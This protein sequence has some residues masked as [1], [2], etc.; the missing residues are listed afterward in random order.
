MLFKLRGNASNIIVN[1]SNLL[2]IHIDDVN[3]CLTLTMQDT[4]LIHSYYNSN[5]EMQYD[6]DLMLRFS[7]NY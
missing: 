1:L 5:T 6:I 4:Q 7:G 2:Y 3:S